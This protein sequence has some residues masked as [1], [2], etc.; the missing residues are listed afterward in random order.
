MSTSNNLKLEL[1]KALIA[2]EDP[3][4]LERVKALL[5]VDSSK[6]LTEEQKAELDARLQKSESG[7]GKEYSWEEVKT[8]A[9]EALS[10]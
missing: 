5:M 6:A 9:R 7:S 10:K 1:V 2:T 4:T 8:I 3:E